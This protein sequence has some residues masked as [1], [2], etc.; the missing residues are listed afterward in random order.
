M[1][2]PEWE[3]IG[4]RIEE[5]YVKAGGEALRTTIMQSKVKDSTTYLT[6]I[7]HR[8]TPMR[9]LYEMSDAGPVWFTEAYY[10]KMIG[11]PVELIEVPEKENIK[12]QYFAGQLKSA[13]HPEAAKDFMDFLISKEANEIYHKYGFELP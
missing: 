7:H 13:P 3:G 1:P 2:N 8:Q 6:Q 10:Q 12:A 9:I 4:K 5:A 11:H